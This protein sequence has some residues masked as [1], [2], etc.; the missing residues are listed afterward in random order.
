M[1]RFKVGQ[2]IR[3]TEPKRFLAIGKIRHTHYGDL[4]QIIR[5]VLDSPIKWIHVDLSLSS[6]EFAMGEGYDAYFYPHEI[7][8]ISALE[9][10]AQQAEESSKQDS[11]LSMFLPV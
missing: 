3:V 9:A 8:P 7:K 1:S 11:A 6:K 2:M 4:G 10:L 5:I